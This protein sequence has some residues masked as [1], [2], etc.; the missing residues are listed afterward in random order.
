[1]SPFC[2]QYQSALLGDADVAG[3]LSNLD[4]EKLDAAQWQALTIP[5]NNFDQNAPPCD[6][7]GQPMKHCISLPVLGTAG[8][9]TRVFHCEPC[10]RLKWLE[11][12]A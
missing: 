10:D 6:G 9:M 4:A 3:D 5:M 12:G 2:F 1:M 11:D 7:C 8:R